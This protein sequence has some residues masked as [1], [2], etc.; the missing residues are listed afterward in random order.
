[1]LQ[2]TELKSELK[3]HVYYWRAERA[4]ERCVSYCPMVLFVSNTPTN[5]ERHTYNGSEPQRLQQSV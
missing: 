1:M 3:K 2:K 5:Y 4:L